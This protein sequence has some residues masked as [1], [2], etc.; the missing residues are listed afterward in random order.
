MFYIL[1]FLTITLLL[2]LY[3][4]NSNKTDEE[5]K[6]MWSKAQ[7]KTKIIERSGTKFN[8]GKNMDLALKDAETRLQSGGGLFGN[9]G[10]DMDGII[11]G[12]KNKEDAVVGSV[13][14][15]IT[16]FYGKEHWKL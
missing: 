16:L 4:C 13:A 14:M 7:T 10:L 2:F 5:M 9:T 11:N 15:P 1:K 8:S 3:S 12:G 6:E